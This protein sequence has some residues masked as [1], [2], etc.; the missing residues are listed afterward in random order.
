MQREA[1]GKRQAAMEAELAMLRAENER[2]S[3][4]AYRDA[5]TGLR[6]RRYFTERLGE[7]VCRLRRRS[8][9]HLSVLTLDVNAFKALND[10]RGHMAGD[11]ALQAVGQLLQALVREEDLCCRLGGDEFAVLLPDTDA[12]QCSLVLERIRS[13]MGA[14]A[15]VGLGARGL[16]LGAASW[17]EGDDEARLLNRADVEMYGDKRRAKVTHRAPG[18]VGSQFASAA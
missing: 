7:E 15:E 18:S 11:A 5:L 14:L 3:R 6:N 12:S 8:G 13:A 10:T 9:A 4:L 2:L 1:R 17:E 16:A